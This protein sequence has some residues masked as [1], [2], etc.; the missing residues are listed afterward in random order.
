[1]PFKGN[2]PWFADGEPLEQ[3]PDNFYSSEFLVDKMMAFME[4]ESDKDQPFFAY[5][6]FQAIHIPVQAPAEFVKKYKGVYKD[7]W[8]KVKQ[9]RF[10]KAKQL[11]IIQ[12]DAILG[13]MHPELQKWDNLSSEAQ[14]I[15]ANDMAVNA[16]ML[17]AMDYHLS[18][19]HI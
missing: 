9:Q 11:G 3:L 17:E 12:K 8:D 19:I 10:E 15:A 16:A 5:L 18:L 4:E 13:E 2:A 14:Q 6:P 1:M 7:G